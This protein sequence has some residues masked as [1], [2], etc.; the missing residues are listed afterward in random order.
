MSKDSP[1][2]CGPCGFEHVTKTAKKWC[3][4]C[5]EGFCEECE[6]VH[7][8]TKMSR[9]HQLISISDYMQMQNISNGLFN[10]YLL[11]FKIINCQATGIYKLLY[12][13]DSAID[14]VF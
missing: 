5:G 4:N 11:S 13:L 3:S 7:R 12:I 14:G 1:V 6:K 8:A 2:L 10:S 9:A